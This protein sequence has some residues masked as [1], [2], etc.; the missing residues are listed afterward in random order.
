MKSFSINFFGEAKN[1]GLDDTGLV[2]VEGEI[3]FII[4]K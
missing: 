1:P 2:W 3:F 4:V